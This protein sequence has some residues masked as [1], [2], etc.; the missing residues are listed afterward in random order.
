MPRK[1]SFLGLDN[2]G[3]TSIIKAITQKFGFEEE[4]KEILPTRK[5]AR[6]QFEFLGIKFIR[7]D[8]GGQS[9]YREEYLKDPGKYLGG[10]DLIFYVIDIQDPER[11]M[12]S[13]DYLEDILLYFKEIQEYPPVLVLFHKFDPDLHKSDF[14]DQK[15]L[16]LKQSLMKYSYDYDIFF[17]ETSI[18]DLKSVMDAFS[19]GLALLFDKVEMVSQ[20]FEEMSKNYDTLLIA[21]FDSNGFTI[22]EYSKPKIRLDAKMSIYR[23]Y[24][25]V[26]K[27]ITTESKFP[28][29][30]SDMFQ[31]G[32][33]YSGVIEELRFGELKFYLLFILLENEENLEQ[34]INILDEIEA[35]QTKVE[36]IL[37]QIIQ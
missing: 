1:I 17:L 3:K 13:I 8:F 5:V 34:T 16:T 37:S 26:Q 33:R 31:N 35:A 28:Y 10:T 22:G 6:D 2:A 7:M 29:E 9:L 36:S 32:Q 25:E 21:L 14:F 27:R 15:T 24:I 19:S 18:Y 23:S 4:I 11:Y 20:L 30:F 12:E